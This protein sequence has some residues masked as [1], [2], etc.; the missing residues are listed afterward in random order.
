MSATNKRS[1]FVPWRWF[2]WMSLPVILFR[3]HLLI[4]LRHHLARQLLDA[5]LAADAQ[6]LFVVV[7]IVVVVDEQRLRRGAD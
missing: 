4:D 7:V 2:R 3:R 1:S 6:V 5:A